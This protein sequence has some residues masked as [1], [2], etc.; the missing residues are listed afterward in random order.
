M[1]IFEHYN[2]IYNAR[3]VGGQITNE[4]IEDAVELAEYM[5]I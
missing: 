4:F 3:P 2:Q 5:A 1:G